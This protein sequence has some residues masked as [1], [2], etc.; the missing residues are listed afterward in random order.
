M[1]TPFDGA[2]RLRRREIDEMRVAISVQIDRLTEVEALQADTAAAMR[3]ESE[4]AADDVLLSSHAYMMRI[5][6]ERA[7]LAADQVAIDSRLAQLR[8]RALDAYGSCRAIEEAAESHRED[9]AQA[10]ASAEQGHIDDL[11][12]ASFARGMLAVRRPGAR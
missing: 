8:A 9:A 4:I 7:R 12:G 11:S 3:R 10:E 2:I 6:A 1:K 5:R